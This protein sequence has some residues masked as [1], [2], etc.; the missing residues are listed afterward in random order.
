MAGAGVIEDYVADL[1][2]R[3][4]G[5]KRAKLDLLTEARDSLEDAAECYRG[6]GLSA[7]DAERK[8]VGDFGPAPTIALDYQAELAAAYG[9]RTLRSILFVLPLV[10]L[11]WEGARL[12]WAGPWASWGASPPD[13]Y[14]SF[15]R[16]HDSVVWAVTIAAALALL[17]GRFAGRRIGDSRMIARCAAGVALVSI[18]T[19]LLALLALVVA[20]AVFD[21]HRLVMTPG[22]AFAGFVCLLV[23]LRLLVMA[24]RTAQFCS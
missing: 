2:L 15:A 20:T 4:R 22:T 19:A 11:F 3:L 10:Q 14:Y 17:A 9:A 13:W 7:E 23:M 5:A 18:V 6:A 1:D 21:I 24:R 12:L 8:A 16:L